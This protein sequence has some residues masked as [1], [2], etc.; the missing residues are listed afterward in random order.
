[1]K[2]NSILFARKDRKTSRLVIIFYKSLI[3]S[4]RVDAKLY[5]EILRFAI[6]NE[7]DVTDIGEKHTNA[8]QEET[9][10]VNLARAK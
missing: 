4:E 6:L 10:G 5:C 3:A 7:N 9:H 1:M 2:I 8:K